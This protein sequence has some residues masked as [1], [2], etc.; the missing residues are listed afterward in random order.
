V[1]GF[2]HHRPSIISLSQGSVQ[3]LA[4]GHLIVGWGGSNPYV[5]EFDSTG[6]P[7]LDFKFA[8]SNDTYR[9]YK[10]EWT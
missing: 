2:V 6:H 7:V 5:T 10:M 1:H 9:A 3:A 8:P 4:G